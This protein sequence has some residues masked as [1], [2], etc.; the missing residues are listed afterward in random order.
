[1]NNSRFNPTPSARE[2]TIQTNPVARAIGNKK[3]RKIAI[4]A[5]C[6]QCM[7]CNEHHLEPGFRKDI[8]NCTSRKCALWNFRP[9]QNR[10][11]G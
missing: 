3:S 4:S 1:M 8:A 10:A 9:Y 5:F 11:K 2:S 6:A 7:G